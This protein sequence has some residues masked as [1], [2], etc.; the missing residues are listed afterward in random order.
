MVMMAMLV[1]VNVTNFL[2]ITTV[3]PGSTIVMGRPLLAPPLTQNN[4]ALTK[5]LTLVFLFG[6]GD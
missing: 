2:Q 6:E 4:K 5:F 3:G 1:V